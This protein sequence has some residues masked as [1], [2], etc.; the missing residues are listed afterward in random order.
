MLL[1]TTKNWRITSYC[2]IVSL[3]DGVEIRLI[4]WSILYIKSVILTG[5]RKRIKHWHKFSHFIFVDISCKVWTST[6]RTLTQNPFIDQPNTLKLVGY[7]FS[8]LFFLKFWFD[9]SNVTSM[10]LLHQLQ[11]VCF[12]VQRWPSLYW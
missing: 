8:C 2:C 6:N 3:L 4:V 11:F 9:K 10:T 5:T 12:V 1:S 7:N